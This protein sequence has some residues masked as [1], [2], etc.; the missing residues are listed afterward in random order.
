MYRIWE[1]N[2]DEN[3]TAKRN[4]DYYYLIIITWKF[5]EGCVFVGAF[6]SAWRCPL[7]RYHPSSSSSSAYLWCYS[8]SS[9]SSSNMEG[10]I[11]GPCCIMLIDAENET[12]HKGTFVTHVC[13]Y[14]VFF[15]WMEKKTKKL[16]WTAESNRIKKLIIAN[17]SH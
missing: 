3:K 16:N 11:K 6:V 5:G 15:F 8:L 1:H 2:G 14:C 7:L 17:N 4:F 13:S 9:S 10:E 12:K